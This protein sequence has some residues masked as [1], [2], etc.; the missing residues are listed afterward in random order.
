MNIIE[1]N[2]RIIEQNYNESSILEGM[3]KH[4]E[5]CGRNCY[6]SEDKITKKSY[7]KFV[8]GL[9]KAKHGAMLE[10]GTVYLT[11]PVGTPLDD[12]AYMQK[13]DLIQFFKENKYSVVNKN[14][15]SNV[16]NIEGNDLTIVT[17][18]YYITTN[19]RVI[20]ENEKVDITEYLEDWKTRKDSLK[21]SVLTYM[22]KPQDS[23]EKRYT[24]EFTY[25]IAVA[26]D[27]N[28]HRVQSVAEESTRYCNYTQEKFGNGLNIVPP[29][30]FSTDAVNARLE[31]WE[32]EQAHDYEGD[33][34]KEMCIEI[35][36]DTTS[37][38]TDVDWWLYA[39]LSCEKTY[40]MLKDHYGWSNQDCSLILPMDTKTCSIHTASAKDW[41][42]FFN[43][44]ALGTTGSPRPSIKKLASQLMETFL[45]NGWIKTEDLDG[46]AY[47]KYING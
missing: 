37:K 6:K 24:V 44:R 38:W 36:S 26:R 3:L 8:D 2:F 42:H 31:F 45:V 1:S 21:N 41:C 4:I 12:A 11:I 29:E 19:W 32:K 5:V 14:R 34:L 33:I 18:C 40:F 39:N 47:E 22:T 7:Q 46:P 27:V 9:V 28:R 43:L 25:H 23:H 10:H 13:M 20:V 17:D 30:T 15:V 16:V 35:A